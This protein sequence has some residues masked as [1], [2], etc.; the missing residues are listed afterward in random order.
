MTT[1]TVVPCSNC[2]NVKIVKDR[3]Q[4]T[5]CGRCNTTFSFKT[6]EKL[7]TT[8][9][10]DEAREA[11]SLFQAKRNNLEDQYEGVK[12]QLQNITV[13]DLTNEQNTSKSLKEKGLDAIRSTDTKMD[14]KLQ[15]V[16]EGYSEEQAEDLFTRFKQK[17]RII[18]KSDGSFEQV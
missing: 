2:K 12:K 5:S 6:I 3:P 1:Y 13:E 17:G 16:S 11:R 14:F 8:E 10:I 4:K 18:V 9:S 7:H 15:L